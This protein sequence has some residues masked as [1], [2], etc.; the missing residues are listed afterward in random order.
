MVEVD[1]TPFAA[2]ATPLEIWPSF[3]FAEVRSSSGLLVP[4][5][6]DTRRCRNLTVFGFTP[7]AFDWKSVGHP[8]EAFDYPSPSSVESRQSSQRPHF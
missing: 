1:P 6:A 4:G 3:A 8:I 7:K 5:F 2:V